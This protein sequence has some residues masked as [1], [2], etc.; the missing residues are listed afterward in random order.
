[1]TTLSRLEAALASINGSLAKLEA[2]QAP[3]DFDPKPIPPVRDRR[4]AKRRRASLGAMSAKILGRLRSGAATNAELAA[5]FHP[6][7]AWRTRLSDV[8]FYLKSLTPKETIRGREIE[9]GLWL[10]WTERL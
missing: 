7:A 9:D 6:G 8:R 4:V 2:L 10:Y 3:L 1:M 5:L